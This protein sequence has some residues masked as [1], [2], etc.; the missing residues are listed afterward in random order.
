V[1]DNCPAL[2]EIWKK[3]KEEWFRANNKNSACDIIFFYKLRYS[4]SLDL[5]AGWDSFVVIEEIKK[6]LV[7]GYKYF[8]NLIEVSCS[9]LTHLNIFRTSG[10]KA[11][12]NSKSRSKAFTYCL[13]LPITP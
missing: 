10:T 9:N 13:R 5:E 6:S 1:L 3:L 2:S 11:S 8:L 7:E 12:C 4:Y